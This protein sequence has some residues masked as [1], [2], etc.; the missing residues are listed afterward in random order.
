MLGGGVVEPEQEYV[1]MHE[2]LTFSFVPGGAEPIKGRA[3]DSCS[4]L[5]ETWYRTA[6]LVAFTY[7]RGA[8]P[9]IDPALDARREA[10]A[11]RARADS[12]PRSP[13]GATARSSVGLYL[14]G[15]LDSAEVG[16]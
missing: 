11:A 2:Y 12:N 15:G 4:Y 8:G 6:N 7:D 9:E 13:S 3:A 1:A 5:F 10:I 16:Y 14:S